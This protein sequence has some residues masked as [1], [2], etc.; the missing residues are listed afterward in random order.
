MSV[1]FT[2]QK[3]AFKSQLD[4]SSIPCYLL[5]SLSFFISQSRQ[6]LNYQWIDRESS[7]LLDSFS[8]A[9]GQIELLFLHLMDCSSTPPQYLYLSMTI[10][11]IPSSTA[12]SILV[13]I[14]DHF[15]NTFLDRCLDTSRHLH[16]SRFTEGLYNLRVRSTTH[17]LHLMDCS[18]DLFLDSSFIFSPKHFHL[19]PILILKVSSS[20]FK[21]LLTW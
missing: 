12:V 11:S 16:L 4:T 2:S 13:S 6:L 10:S 19:T 3:T 5:S 9:G 8:T 1:F 17:A 21:I 7:C 15:L 18:F 20:F 14:D